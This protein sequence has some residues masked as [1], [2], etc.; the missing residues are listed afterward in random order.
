M[1]GPDGPIEVLV[2]GSGQPVTVFAH[3][4]AGSIEG[5]RP[6]GSGVAGTRVFFHFHGHGATVEAQSLWTYAALEAELRA[7][8]DAYSARRALGVSLGAGALLGAAARTPADYDRLV[9]VLPAAVAE[10]RTDP[11]IERMQRMAE[12]VDERD[13]AGLA[14]ALVAEQPPSVR[15]RADV[16]RWA[17]LQAHRLAATTVSSAL[18][19][20]P[21]QHP[22]EDQSSLTAITCLALV[23]GQTE[24]AAHPARIA[25][26]LVA[27]LPNARLRVFTGGGLLWSHRA[28]L[29]SLIGSFLNT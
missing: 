18:R 4:L 19:E 25:R 12:L 2:T 26:E 22:L 8:T 10:P 14:A 9:F 23:V 5:T 11:A 6:F 17:D 24:D 3:G 29:R 28:E 7:V 20:L 27:G 1:T 15:D 21:S 16:R 13:H